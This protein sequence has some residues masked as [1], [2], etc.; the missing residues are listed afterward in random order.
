MRKSKRELRQ[1]WM[2]RAAAPATSD[3]ALRDELNLRK[4]RRGPPSGNQNRLTHGRYTRERL[5]L[6]ADSRMLAILSKVLV[7]L[8]DRHMARAAA[9]QA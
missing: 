6:Q 4:S 3:Q 5:S 9:A 1:R 8:C 2:A 7:A